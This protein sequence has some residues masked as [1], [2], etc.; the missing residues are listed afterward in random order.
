MGIGIP[1]FAASVVQHFLVL[2]DL[3]SGLGHL[4]FESIF[5]RYFSVLQYV[6][7]VL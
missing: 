2:L 5:P 7:S 1:E 3:K 6:P 4:H